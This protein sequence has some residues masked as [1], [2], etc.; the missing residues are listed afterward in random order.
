MNDLFGRVCFWMKAQIRVVLLDVVE[1]WVI[2]FKKGLTAH[3]PLGLQSWCH[4]MIPFIL[5]SF[6][7]HQLSTEKRAKVHT[8]CASQYFGCLAAGTMSDRVCE[9]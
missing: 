4:K 9:E 3:A 8:S 2:S 6:V 5:H 1:V 7:L